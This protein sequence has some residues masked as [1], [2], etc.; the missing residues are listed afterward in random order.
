MQIA[1]PVMSGGKPVGVLI[2]GVNLSRLSKS[3]AK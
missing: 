3:T 2:V 1:A